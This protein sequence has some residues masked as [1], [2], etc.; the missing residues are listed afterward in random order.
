M[1]AGSRPARWKCSRHH[2]EP[3]AACATVQRIA[4][5][6]STWTGAAVTSAGVT[7]APGEARRPLLGEGFEALA[8]VRA[9]QELEHR[10]AL[11]EEP[12]RQLAAP[13]LVD[14]ALDQADC[15]R[16][17]G[18]ELLGE[19]PRPRHDGVVGDDLVHEAVLERLGG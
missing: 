8:E 7:S 13:A 1:E 3:A 16:R 11:A 19:L 15:A 18:G 10:V 4:A 5:S 17:P 6:T 12:G 9:L 14:E 2:E